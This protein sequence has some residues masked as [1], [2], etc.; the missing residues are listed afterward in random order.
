[1]QLQRIYWD[2]NIKRSMRGNKYS[3]ELEFCGLTPFVYSSQTSSDILHKFNRSVAPLLSSRDRPSI[4]FIHGSF[5]SGNE[6][7]S[8]AD[9]VFANSTCFP[10]E[11]IVDI[12]VACRRLRVGARV[13]TFTS[14]LRSE[15]F[16]V[17]SRPE[18]ESVSF[19]I[20][21]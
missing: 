13:I 20:I 17:R 9:L 14:S 19:P 2:R 8:D 6:D 11:L 12:E 18:T 4:N 15:F 21:I 7:W 10:D 5:L 1:M 16:K 3:L